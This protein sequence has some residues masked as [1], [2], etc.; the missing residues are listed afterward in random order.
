[1]KFNVGD[2]VKVIVN[3]FGCSLDDVGKIVTI[4][5]QHPTRYEGRPAYRVSPPIGNTRTWVEDG[6]EERWNNFDGFIGET[7]FEFVSIS[8]KTS[9]EGSKIKFNFLKK[10]VMTY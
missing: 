9:Y 2:V 6:R 7:S 10:R 1:M 4:V 8:D 5:E 3:G